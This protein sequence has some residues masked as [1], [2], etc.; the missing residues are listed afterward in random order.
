MNKQILVAAAIPEAYRTFLTKMLGPIDVHTFNPDGKLDIKFDM[1]L[2]TGGADVTPSYYGEKTGR[3]T[4]INERRDELEHYICK[5][6]RNTPK[7]GIC[8]GSQFLTVMA[9]GKLI[10][11]VTGHGGEHEIQINRAGSPGRF[12]TY[13]ISSTHHQMMYPFSLNK[14]QYK[15]L[16]WSKKFRSDTYLNGDNEEIA[17]PEDFLEPEIVF[18]EKDKSLCIQ[19]HPE[20]A[21]TPAETLRLI[22]SYI[23]TYLMKK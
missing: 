12:S 2:L 3:Q 21:D 17:L 1:L 5:L 14:A 4:G 6:Y 13:R 16:A 8:R 18:Y 20:F 9:G 11:H 7:L 19:G 22:K 10:Q 23:N 15:L